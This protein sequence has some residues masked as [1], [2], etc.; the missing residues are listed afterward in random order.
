M[1]TDFHPPI[2]IKPDISYSPDLQISDI[3]LANCSIDPTSIPQDTL[4][5]QH[6]FLQPQLIGI[7][8]DVSHILSTQALSKKYHKPC[9]PGAYIPSNTAP[10]HQKLYSSLN[11]LS[12]YSIQK[13]Y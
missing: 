12:Y 4:L 7:Q 3:H 9:I 10:G 11:N 8:T 6:D 1:F 13:A 2:V 5:F